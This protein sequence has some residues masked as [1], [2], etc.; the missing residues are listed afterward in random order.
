SA[1]TLGIRRFMSGVTCEF[2]K[3]ITAV[4]LLL[5][6]GPF[7]SCLQEPLFETTWPEETDSCW[8]L[9]NPEP[10]FP[11]LFAV[12]VDKPD[13][14]MTV[15]SGGGSAVYDGLTWEPIETGVAAVLH[16]VWGTSAD[17]VWAVG[18][19]GTVVHNNGAVWNSLTCGTTGMRGPGSTCPQ[20]RRSRTF[21]GSR[22]Q[23]YS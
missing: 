2:R 4:A 7:N 9:L 17:N 15:G 13:H 11:D 12:W 8:T 3:W 16:D 18:N 6:V 23:M 19:G 1:N 20:Q 5:A 22:Q 10:E 21:G 14:V